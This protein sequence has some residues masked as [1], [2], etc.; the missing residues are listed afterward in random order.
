MS[1]FPFQ[2]KLYI[3]LFISAMI[4]VEGFGRTVNGYISLGRANVL[5]TVTCIDPTYIYILPRVIVVS[6]S[7]YCNERFILYKYDIK[8]A[9]YIIRW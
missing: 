5:I 9:I 3:D 7:R 8:K 1:G 2:I 4:L 6:D